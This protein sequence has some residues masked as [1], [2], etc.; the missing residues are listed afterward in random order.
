MISYIILIAS[1]ASKKK[2]KFDYIMRQKTGYFSTEKSEKYERRSY[3]ALTHFLS[4]ARA[5]TF[6]SAAQSG[7][8]MSGAL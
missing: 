2:Y 3:L 4:G 7:A 6:V 5:H 1:K 8:Q